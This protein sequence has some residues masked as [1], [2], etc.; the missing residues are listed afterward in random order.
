MTYESHAG[1]KYQ[2]KNFALDAM[3]VDIYYK[4]MYPSVL[5]SK[6]SY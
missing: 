4:Y 5:V 6:A 3:N 2:T 1:Q